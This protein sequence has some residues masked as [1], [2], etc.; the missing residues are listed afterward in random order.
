MFIFR[1]V[2]FLVVVDKFC[3]FQIVLSTK[4]VELAKF[5][6]CK[7]VSF[8][9]CS[10][11]HRP[12]NKKKLHKK[13]SASDTTELI[14]NNNKQDMSMPKSTKFY[15][16]QG[17]NTQSHPNLVSS[18]KKKSSTHSHN[19]LNGLQTNVDEV[20]MQEFLEVARNGNAIRLKE[21]VDL[22]NAKN[23]TELNKSFDIN[24]RGFIQF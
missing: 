3:L 14:M 17:P 16:D 21:L 6:K 9:K 10:L 18:L 22:G 19:S 23:L 20:F 24:Y 5:L 1:R 13:R 7:K 12:T 4:I 8:S 2:F 11:F 15:I